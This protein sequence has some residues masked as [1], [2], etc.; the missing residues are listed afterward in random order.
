MRG[1]KGLY[2]PEILE[3]FAAMPG[4]LQEK[5]QMLELSVRDAAVGMVFGEEL[6]SSKGLL[7]IAPGQE[8]TLALLERIRNFSPELVIREPVRMILQ[9]SGSTTAQPVL[10]GSR[11]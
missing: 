4:S 5:I 7:L 8:V 11:A 9:P 6:K 1:R 2:D 3:A 10:T